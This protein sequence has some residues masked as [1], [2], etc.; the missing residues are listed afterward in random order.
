MKRSYLK[1]ATQT[2][3]QLKY[4]S[5]M[6][7]LS[8]TIGDSAEAYLTGTPFPEAVFSEY[9]ANGGESGGAF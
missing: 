7:G 4:S 8:Y 5:E 1:R 9:L 6:S 2:V 3:L